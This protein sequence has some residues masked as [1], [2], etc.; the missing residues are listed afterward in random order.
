M[1]DREKYG[2]R[3]VMTVVGCLAALSLAGPLSRV[4]SVPEVA[5]V[6]LYLETGRVVKLQL[7]PPEATQPPETVPPATEPTEQRVMFDPEDADLIQIRYHWDCE[8]DTQAMLLSE[9]C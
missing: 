3:L 8:L 9:L 6:I 4:L 2:L 7:M 1:F 5:S